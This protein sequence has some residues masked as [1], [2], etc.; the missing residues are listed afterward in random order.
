MQNLVFV[1]AIVGFCIDVVVL[2][3]KAVALSA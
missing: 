2:L 1:L 3:L